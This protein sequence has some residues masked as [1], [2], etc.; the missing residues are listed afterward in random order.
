MA[1]AVAWLVAGILATQ[2]QGAAKPTPAQQA[3]RET[4]SVCTALMAWSIDHPP[5]GEYLEEGS[6]PRVD[7]GRAERLPVSGAKSM[8]VPNYFDKVPG[9]DP[10]G[11][12]YQMLKNIDPKQPWSWATRSA[13]PDGK[14]CGD[15]YLVPQPDWDKCDDIVRVDGVLVA[16]PERL[17]EK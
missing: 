11:R 2:G 13:G 15:S 4:L 3:S 8:L 1:L 5:E 12:P 16:G 17:E 6:F 7:F 14:F 9:P 10:W